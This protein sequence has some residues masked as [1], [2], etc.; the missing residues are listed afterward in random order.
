MKSGKRLF[1]TIGSGFLKGRK[2]ALPSSATTRG[3]K[4]IVQGSFFDSVRDE[5]K[6]KVFIEVFGGS[7]LMA[8]T[9]VSEGA[10]EACAIELDRAAFA[11]LRENV[12]NLN[13]SNLKVYNGD[14]LALTPQI[15]SEI[16]NLN[17]NLILYIDQPFDIREGFADIYERVWNMVGKIDPQKIFLVVIEHISSYAAPEFKFELTKFKE[18][19]FGKTTLSFYKP[20]SVI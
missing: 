4:S 11:T 3:T 16:S 17:G 18:R 2:I 8:I 14:T 19:K 20:Q 15:A 6:S 12:S 13:I 7:G 1:T 10:K 5:L 9:A